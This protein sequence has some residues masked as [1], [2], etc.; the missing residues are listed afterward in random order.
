MT[1]TQ[2]STTIQLLALAV[3]ALVGAWL[4]IRPTWRTWRIAYA[5]IHDRWRWPGAAIFSLLTVVGI[6]VGAA[7][8]LA[9]LWVAFG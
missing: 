9:I 6:G 4:L 3:G 2:V 8:G 7:L 1:H 5:F